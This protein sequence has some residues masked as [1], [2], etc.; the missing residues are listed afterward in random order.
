VGADDASG[1]A[2]LCRTVRVVGRDDELRAAD[3]FLE[4][5]AR[6]FALLLLEGEAAIGKTAACDALAGVHVPAGP[7]RASPAGDF[8]SAPVGGRGRGCVL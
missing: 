1:Q 3:E 7:R 8:A 4:H 2:M 5:A 6:R